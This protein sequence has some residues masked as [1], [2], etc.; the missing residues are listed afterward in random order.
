MKCPFC[1]SEA[2]QVKDSRPSEDGKVIRRRR[3]CNDC[4]RRFTTFE[5]FEVQQVI[6]VKRDDRRELFD[7]DKLV[8]SLMMA[9]R[10]RP[11]DREQVYRLVGEIE[12]DFIEEG[13]SEVT[14]RDIGDAV[15][16]KLKELDFVGFV[17]YASVYNSFNNEQDFRK[18]MLNES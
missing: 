12:Q 4:N 9:L 16:P 15:L 5:R 18:I 6:V 13:K 8:H 2:T 14:S 17:R 7:R 10:K 1:G 11:V 3:E